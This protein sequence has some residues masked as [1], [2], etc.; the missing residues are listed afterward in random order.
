[1]FCI[2][3]EINSN[4]IRE[5]L[6][7]FREIGLMEDKISKKILIKKMN[8]FF[9]TRPTYQEILTKNNVFRKST[10]LSKEIEYI[11]IYI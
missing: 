10:K 1:M 5:H 3:Y 8:D 4:L 2:Y 6:I 9:E 11:Y 7:V